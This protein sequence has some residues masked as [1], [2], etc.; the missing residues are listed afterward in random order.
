MV[1]FL[2]EVNDDGGG[3]DGLPHQVAHKELQDILPLNIVAGETL[4]R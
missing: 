3:G 2:E 4:I 1:K